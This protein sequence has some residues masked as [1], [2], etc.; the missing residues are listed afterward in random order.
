MSATGR[1]TLRH[2]YVDDGGVAL[3]H[4]G[5]VTTLPHIIVVD[6]DRDIRQLIA[7]LLAGHGFRVTGVADGIALRTAMARAPDVALVVLDL[8]LPGDDGLTLCRWLR[9]VSTVP[10]IMLTARGDPIDRIIGLEIGADDYLGKPFEPRELVARIR[11]VLRR[12]AQAP[13]I[14]PATGDDGD[15]RFGGWRLDRRRR[16]LIAADQ[17]IVALSG[18]EYRLLD[19]FLAHPGQVLA[20]E[21][22]HRLTGGAPDEALD[23]AIDLRISRLRGK[24]GDDGAAGAALI[25]TVRGRGYV[26]SETVERC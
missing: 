22:L 21:A 4:I 3:R 9:S 12:A 17:T 14:E 15:L 6:D 19:V 5:A 16:Q 26:F 11:S 24:L 25:K 1:E 23:R 7:E 10:I 20:R 18:A 8:T 2:H 13:G